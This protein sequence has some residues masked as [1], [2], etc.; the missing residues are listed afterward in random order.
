M[1]CIGIYGIVYFDELNRAF[2]AFEILD[3]NPPYYLSWTNGEYDVVL[4]YLGLLDLNPQH[5]LTWIN[6]G[7]YLMVPLALIWIVYWCVRYNRWAVVLI[8]ILVPIPILLGFIGQNGAMIWEWSMEYYAFSSPGIYM[9]TL[10]IILVS[11]IFIR[12]NLIFLRFFQNIKKTDTVDEKRIRSTNPSFLGIFIVSVSPLIPIIGILVACYNPVIPLDFPD[13]YFEIDGFD[14]NNPTYTDPKILSEIDS[15][16]LGLGIPFLD[17]TQIKSWYSSTGTILVKK[18]INIQQKRI[19]DIPSQW[20]VNGVP[21]KTYKELIE[22]LKQENWN[23]EYEKYLSQQDVLSN[24]KKELEIYKDENPEKWKEDISTL[25]KGIYGSG[26]VSLEAIVDIMPDD[27]RNHIR[28]DTTIYYEFYWEQSNFFRLSQIF[29]S[30]ILL[31]ILQEDIEWAI[32]MLRVFHTFNT[33]YYNNSIAFGTSNRGN[34]MLRIE[35]WAAEIVI[36][37]TTNDEQLDRVR[38]IYAIPF[39]I[40]NNQINAW[41]W[42]LYLSA[43]MFTGRQES[44]ESI[45]IPY[46]FNGKDTL[47]IAKMSVYWL[48]I[49]KAN[50][51]NEMIQKIENALIVNKDSFILNENNES[52]ENGWRGQYPFYLIYNPIGKRYW[53][54]YMS[55]LTGYLRRYH[56]SEIYQN[57]IRYDLLGITDK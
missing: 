10:A 17:Q 53:E 26:S 27:F 46:L 50:N 41:K 48:D 9:A 18:I 8:A 36:Q 7:L 57:Y 43:H 44:I 1:I 13:S 35:F 56:A 3:P 11:Y 15:M 14:L 5:Y 49:A 45:S 38:A 12:W 42:E 29:R 4:R 30:S 37:N 19:Y 16:I 24:L 39:D 28:N 2:K 47:D 33:K 23:K 25:E 34:D 20:P 55:T 22:N 21:I 51:D 52:S 31:S 6:I 54:F 32:D 40:H